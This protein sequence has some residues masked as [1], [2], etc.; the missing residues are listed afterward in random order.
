MTQSVRQHGGI[1]YLP[2]GC[3][4][5]VLVDGGLDWVRESNKAVTQRGRGFVRGC[6]SKVRAWKSEETGLLWSGVPMRW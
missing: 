4:V 6:D 3:E 1:R 5:V 2:V